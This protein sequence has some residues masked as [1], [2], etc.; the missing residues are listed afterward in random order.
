MWDASGIQ[1]ELL[2]QLPVV[3]L[4]R[5]LRVG[6]QANGVKFA[7]QSLQSTAAHEVSQHFCF[8]SPTRCSADLRRFVAAVLPRLR[9][10]LCAAGFAGCRDAIDLLAEF[11]EQLNASLTTFVA[12]IAGDLAFFLHLVEGRFQFGPKP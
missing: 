6:L 3:D 8:T 2:G 7:F 11:G 9:C 4:E 12:D 10:R 1:T 5:S